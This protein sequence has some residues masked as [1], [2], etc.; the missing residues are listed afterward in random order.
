MD[1]L[2]RMPVG[3]AIVVG[4]VIGLALG[5]VVSLTTDVP[6]APEVGAVLGGLA[7]GP[8]SCVKPSSAGCRSRN[9]W[10]SIEKQR[11]GET[12]GSV[13]REKRS[14]LSQSGKQGN[15]PLCFPGM[16]ELGVYVSTVTL[17]VT[18]DHSGRTWR[19]EP[20]SDR[21]RRLSG[22]ASADNDHPASRRGHSPAR[23]CDSRPGSG[24]SPTASPAWPA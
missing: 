20:R 22:P 7:L 5:I 24:A 13:S 15:G 1:H 3:A 16:S 19:L 23:A 8:G 6:L 12:S 4:G 10:G 17:H 14:L 9:G 2:S 18:N 11:S 21:G